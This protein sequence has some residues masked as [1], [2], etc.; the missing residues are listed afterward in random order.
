M[1]LDVEGK[2]QVIRN[3]F[4]H[5]WNQ[6]QY[7]SF[8]KFLNEKVFLNFRGTRQGT[9]LDELKQL[10]T[11]WRTAFPDLT[12]E[13][14]DIIAETDLAAANLV[15]TGTHTGEWQG[16]PPSGQKIRVEEMMFFQFEDGKIV[17]MWEVYDEAAMLNQIKQRAS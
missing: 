1:S 10:V 13:I 16:I 15:F 8:S 9:N 17:E 14:L 5:G 7:D 2:K 11:F 12:F 6:E 4:E 3:I